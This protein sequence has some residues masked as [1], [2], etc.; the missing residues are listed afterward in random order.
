[1][2][3]T[4]TYLCLLSSLGRPYYADRVTNEEIGMG[5]KVKPLANNPK[6]TRPNGVLNAWTAVPQGTLKVRSTP[7]KNGKMV[8]P[9]KNSRYES[10]YM[11]SRAKKGASPH[12]KTSGFHFLWF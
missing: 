3:P 11:P 8:S 9:M 4:L 5:L 1:M 12:K 6:L 2:L 10:T 7:Y